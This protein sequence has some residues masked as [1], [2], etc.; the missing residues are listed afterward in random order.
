MASAVLKPVD[1]LLRS[2]LRVW[3]GGA[4]ECG[5]IRQ[6]CWF[7]QPATTTGDL[8]RH[9]LVVTRVKRVY[10]AA[11]LDDVMSSR[12]REEYALIR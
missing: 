4:G 2:P 6:V 3:T 8:H 10:H 7:A 5:K 1:L 12:E 9:W 11:R